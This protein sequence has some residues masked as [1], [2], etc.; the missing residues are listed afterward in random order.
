MFVTRFEFVNLLII[1]DHLIRLSQMYHFATSKSNIIIDT[2]YLKKQD[3]SATFVNTLKNC[4][5][6]LKWDKMPFAGDITQMVMRSILTTTALLYLPEMPFTKFF[7]LG[8]L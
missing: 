3:Y 4:N 8:E 7:L 1:F 6:N 5:Y 2:E